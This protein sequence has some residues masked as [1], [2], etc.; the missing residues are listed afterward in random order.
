MAT[1]AASSSGRVTSVASSSAAYERFASLAA[2]LA[3]SS[4]FLY[5]VS[6]VI[7]KSSLLAAVFLLLLGLLTTVV[8]VALYERLKETDQSFALLAVLLGVTA[9]LGSAVH[10]GYDLSNA[11]HPPAAIS[12]DLPS[13]IDP[14]GLLTFGVTGLG[15]W[16][17][18]WLMSQ[19]S[20]FPKP[21]A[22]VGYLA[23]ALS[24]VLYLG[25]LIVLDATSLLI[26]VPVLLAGF[27]VQ[28]LFYIWLGLRLRR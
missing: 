25:R 22:Y 8:S 13:A 5:A 12:P 3:G 7:L 15:L 18:A 2:L 11:L 17:V 23:A 4:A 27:I 14:R 6:F 26:V 9:A 28:P 10:G 21:L 19:N 1:I 16:I 24:I 20:H